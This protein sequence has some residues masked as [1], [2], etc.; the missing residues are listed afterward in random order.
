V[1][2][3]PGKIPL[4]TLCVK[5]RLKR[6]RNFVKEKN[7]TKEFLQILQFALTRS[8]PEKFPPHGKFPQEKT[9]SRKIAP[10]PILKC[11]HAFQ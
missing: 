1:K 4:K 3:Y 8:P 6:E 11:I 2:I 9:S 5:L 10:F 7:F